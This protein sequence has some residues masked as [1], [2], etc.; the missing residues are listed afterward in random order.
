M[1]IC[2]CSNDHSCSIVH[3]S[4]SRSNICSSNCTVDDGRSP[5][6]A[7]HRLDGC[8]PWIWFNW[9]FPVYIG[10]TTGSST[11]STHAS[12]CTSSTSQEA[13]YQKVDQKEELLWLVLRHG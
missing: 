10:S 1:G 5:K 2:S 9:T 7:N 13:R 11:T 8:L 4:P 3:T 6:F 12:T